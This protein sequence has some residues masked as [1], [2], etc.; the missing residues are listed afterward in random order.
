MKEV[1]FSHPL[2]KA[3][4]LRLKSELGIQYLP[5]QDP[6]MDLVLLGIT[7]DE[8]NV[9]QYWEQVWIELGDLDPTQ[10]AE[11]LAEEGVTPEQMMKDELMDILDSMRTLLLA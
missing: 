5:T 4:D 6:L 1:R 7:D 10:I 2:E 11:T 9:D 3:A 8:G